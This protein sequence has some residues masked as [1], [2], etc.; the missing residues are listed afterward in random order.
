[1]V[2]F[3]TNQIMLPEGDYALFPEHDDAVGEA[4]FNA[5]YSLLG[6]DE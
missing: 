1:M 5:Y 3:L 6:Q 2:I 4:V